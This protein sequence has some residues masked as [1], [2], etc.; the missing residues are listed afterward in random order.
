MDFIVNLISLLL[1]I[2]VASADVAFSDVYSSDPLNTPLDYLVENNVVEGYGDGTF[3]PLNLIN[4]AEFTK[5]IVEGVIGE[6]P[7]P[8][9]YHDCFTDV[10]DDW[11]AKYVCYAEDQGWIQGYGNGYFKPGDNITKSEAIKILGEAYSWELLSTLPW[12]E[13]ADN[14][15]T[16]WYYDYILKAEERGI[17]DK[18]SSYVS[19]HELISRR[20][21]VNLLYRAM[22]YE[23]G[24]P[25][26]VW[27]VSG[28][29]LSY[30][31]VL[32]SGLTAAYPSDMSMS[33]YSQSGWP[34]GCY[35]FSVKNVI[36]WKYGDVLDMSDVADTIEWDGSFIWDTTQFSSFAENYDVDL[37]MT[38]YGS[39]EFFLKKLAA[40]EPVVLYIPYYIGEDNVGHQVMAYS[41]DEN[42]VWIADSLY[43]GI[44]RQVGFDEVFLDGSAY[45]TNI[46]DLRKVKDG[47]EYKVEF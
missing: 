19:P 39:A 34:Y 9:I 17:L 38:Y 32:D 35:G 24:Y 15:E 20:Q 22:K 21:M 30:Q 18:L 2:R 33:V 8:D 47:G 27:E 16:E 11:Y 25:V 31:E 23:E 1:S 41:F 42:G 10:T 4:R 26:S 5:M 37:I 43:G 12:S 45:T 46:T 13:F 14:V 28:D 7:D 6:T 44:Q 3:K 36:A 40:G 29:E